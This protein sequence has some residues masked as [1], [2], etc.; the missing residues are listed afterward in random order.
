MTIEKPTDEED[1]PLRIRKE[2]SEEIKKDEN[3]KNTQEKIEEIIVDQDVL[4]LV[5]SRS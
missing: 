4:N 1:E 2:I 3:A 5:E